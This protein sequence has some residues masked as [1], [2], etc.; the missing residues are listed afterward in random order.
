VPSSISNR[1]GIPIV[2]LS[3]SDVLAA[4]TDHDP[5]QPGDAIHAFC[6]NC[7][8]NVEVAAPEGIDALGA[9]GADELNGECVTEFPTATRQR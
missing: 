7:E 2:C 3:C 8:R 1:E 4:E 9:D 6:P 5:I